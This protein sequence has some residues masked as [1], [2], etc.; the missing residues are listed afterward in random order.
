MKLV[1]AFALLT[2]CASEK[3]APQAPVANQQAHQTKPEPQPQRD[4]RAH[5][6]RAAD[7]AAQAAR[8]A[9]ERLDQIARDL[10]ALD[11]RTSAAIDQV[12]AAQNDADRAAA[13]ARLEE[14]QRD[15]QDMEQRIRAAKAAAAKAERAKGVK[16]SPECM[17]NPLAKGCS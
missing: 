9:E 15:K 11:K 2:A 6:Q 16:V 7:D 17:D 8:E 3:P 10:D 12:V 13:K 14:L 1:L 5:A 4:D